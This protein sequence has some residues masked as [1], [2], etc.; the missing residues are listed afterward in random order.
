[1]NNF[2]KESTEFE[3]LYIIKSKI[4]YDERGYFYE[5]YQ[6][7]KFQELGINDE[8]VQDNRSMSHKGVLRRLHFQIQ[9]WAQSKLVSVISGS[10]WD[11]VVDLR[12]NSPTFGKYFSIELKP[13]GTMLYIPQGFAHGFYTLEDNT[14]FCYKCNNY[15]SKSHERCLLYSDPDINIQWPAKPSF[16]SPKDLQGQ[17]FHD[18]ISHLD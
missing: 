5:S 18:L 7:E 9:P 12:K 15:Y 16:I 2:I 14:V 1:M 17:L 13:D 11:V 10:V 3:G 8:F 6:K 4:F